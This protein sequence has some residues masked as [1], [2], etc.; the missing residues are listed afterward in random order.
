M[1][2]WDLKVHEVLLWREIR[3]SCPARDEGVKGDFVLDCWF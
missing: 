2:E 3:K 1:S